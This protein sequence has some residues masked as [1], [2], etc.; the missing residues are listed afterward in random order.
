M[1]DCSSLTDLGPVVMSSLVCFMQKQNSDLPVDYAIIRRVLIQANGGSDRLG[2]VAIT[3]AWVANF[4]MRQWSSIQQCMSYTL[5]PCARAKSCPS[6]SKTL[7]RGTIERQQ[8]M[9][10]FES[11]IITQGQITIKK[12]SSCA[13]KLWPSWYST[14]QSSACIPLSKTEA[15]ARWFMSTLDSV[16]ESVMLLKYQ[17]EMCVWPALQTSACCIGGLHTL[18]FLFMCRCF[19]QVPLYW[20]AEIYNT[21]YGHIPVKGEEGRKA[22]KRTVMKNLSYVRFQDAF[23]RWKCAEYIM[24]FVP[25][26]QPEVDMGWSTEA[27]CSIVRYIPH[28]VSET[29]NQLWITVKLNV[30]RFNALRESRFQSF[31]ATGNSNSEEVLTRQSIIP[32]CFTS[33]Q[34][35]GVMYR[36]QHE[37]FK[38]G[39]QRQ[40]VYF[41]HFWFWRYSLW[42]WCKSCKGQKKM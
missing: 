38:E 1:A 31:H 13:S 29:S 15:D 28:Y 42:M 17:H 11:G 39:L 32:C 30:Q 6:C 12:C 20:K 27:L 16:L 2:N 26:I 9:F 10:F 23:F 34:T 33:G 5:P 8:C 3:E 22:N 4:L 24:S 37:A 35:S 18:F 41:V 7:S 40:V 21:T 36:W 14:A 25:K 19:A